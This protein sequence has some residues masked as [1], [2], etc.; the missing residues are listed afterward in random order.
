MLLQCQRLGCA[1]ACEGDGESH[2]RKPAHG[3]TVRLENG[4]CA[5]ELR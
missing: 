2:I 1:S 5:N 4:K 3:K